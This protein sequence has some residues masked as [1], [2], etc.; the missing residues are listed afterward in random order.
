ML[1]ITHCLDKWLT[2]GSE[3]V[4]PRTNR[5]LL[6]RNIIIFL[7]LVLI[8]VITLD[9]PEISSRNYESL[10]LLVKAKTEVLSLSIQHSF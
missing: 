10:L 3:V 5:T 7:F 8:S 9:K 2:D 4:S 1:R 6:S